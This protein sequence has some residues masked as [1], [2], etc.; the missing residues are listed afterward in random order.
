MQAHKAF[1]LIRLQGM[2]LR[3]RMFALHMQL[4]TDKNG[5]Y[6]GGIA[7]LAGD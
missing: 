1:F 2:Q 7:A 3:M 5:N 4:P 6:N